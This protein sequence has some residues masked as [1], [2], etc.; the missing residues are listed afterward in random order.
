MRS[1]TA[2]YHNEW[3]LEVGAGTLP[4]L[5]RVPV[6]SIVLPESMLTSDE[7]IT[8]IFMADIFALSVAELAKRIILAPTN[9]DIL[10]IN[11]K[12]IRG[13]PGLPQTYYSVDSMGL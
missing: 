8:E 1:E 3:L 12:I 11:N 10:E 6:N 13:L 7:L 2:R 5:P 4:V 9:K